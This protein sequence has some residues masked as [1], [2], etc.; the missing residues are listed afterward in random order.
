MKGALKYLAKF[1]EKHLCRSLFKINLLAAGTS[2]SV[3]TPQNN[4]SVEYVGTASLIYVN[5]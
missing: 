1:A 2:C 4:V 3:K 5:T